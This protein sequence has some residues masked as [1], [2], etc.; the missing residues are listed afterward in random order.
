MQPTTRIEIHYDYF[1]T[2]GENFK[3]GDCFIAVDFAGRNWGSGA[4]CITKE[5]ALQHL[6]STIKSHNLKFKECEFQDF[7]G[8]FTKGEVFS[9]GL[10]GWLN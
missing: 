4:P 1:S 7:T 8:L 3:E 9:V 2:D 10:E 5:A 6:K